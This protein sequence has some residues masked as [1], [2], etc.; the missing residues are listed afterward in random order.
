MKLDDILAHVKRAHSEGEGS[1]TNEQM[2]KFIAV[3]ID[4]VKTSLV[5]RLVRNT[6]KY[7][8]LKKPARFDASF[9]IDNPR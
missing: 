1:V 4:K 2:F 8:R 9:C 6:I 5:D 7:S 3:A